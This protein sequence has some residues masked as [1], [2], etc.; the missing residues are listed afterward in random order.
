[1]SCELSSFIRLLLNNKIS[2]KC[3]NIFRI[4]VLIQVRNIRKILYLEFMYKKK[5]ICIIFHVS[6]IIIIIKC[7]FQLLFLY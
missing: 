7:F 3:L 5:K 2:V 6:V 4:S 1:M